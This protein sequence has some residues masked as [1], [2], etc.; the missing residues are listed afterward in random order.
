MAKSLVSKKGLS[1]VVVTLILIALSMMAVMLIWTFI[2]KMIRSQIESSESCFGN[3]DKVQINGEYTCY[4][5]NGGAYNLRFSLMIGDVK[6]DK[7]RV[8]VSS[9]STVKGY[10]IA[11]GNETIEGLAMYPS[12]SMLINLPAKNAGVTYRATGFT[13]RIDSIRIAPVIGGTVCE[14]S[15][16]IAEIENCLLYE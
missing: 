7:V 2:N 1:T 6:V 10:E 5:E 12:G 3:Y 14:V 16:S 15:D 8:S 4:E 9:E 11:G 13:S